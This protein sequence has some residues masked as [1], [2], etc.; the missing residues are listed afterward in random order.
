MSLFLGTKAKTPTQTKL[1]FAP[2]SNNNNTTTTPPEPYLHVL[3]K[4]QTTGLVSTTTRVIQI[5]ALIDSSDDNDEY[6]A[7][8]NP[9]VPIPEEATRIHSFSA[10][11]V[12][13]KPTMKQVLPQFF[14]WIEQ[15]RKQHNK[16]HVILTSHCNYEFDMLLLQQE[17]M[18][19][20]TRYPS[21]VTFGDVIYILK[22][23]T[24]KPLFKSTEK[25]RKTTDTQ[26]SQFKLEKLHRMFVPDSMFRSGQSSE[27]D[28]TALKQMLKHLPLRRQFYSLLD[29]TRQP[30][31]PENIC[32]QNIIKKQEQKAQSDN[33]PSKQ[34]KL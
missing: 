32:R 9:T 31:S 20:R 28:V 18:L 33:N 6:S 1:Q 3:Y 15:K 7:I 19:T 8:V 26:R 34:I 27:K 12:R 21:H 16:E 24:F 13:D 5:Y 30:F 11:N 2:A 10:D 22:H 29:K 4:L 23:A 25:K 17:I 14:E